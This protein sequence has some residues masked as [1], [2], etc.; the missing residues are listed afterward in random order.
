MIK[1]YKILRINTLDTISDNPVFD[2]VI[3]NAS[4]LQPGM[5]EAYSRPGFNFRSDFCSRIYSI[6]RLHH[7]GIKY[8]RVW[9]SSRQIM[10]HSC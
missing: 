8:D 3:Y 6:Q 9:M 7:I 4:K 1:V 5:Y 10:K 2:P